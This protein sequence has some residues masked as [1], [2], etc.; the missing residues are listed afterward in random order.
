[1]GHSSHHVSIQL[2]G[3]I[4]HLLNKLKQL[5]HQ[6]SVFRYIKE[7]RYLRKILSDFLYVDGFRISTFFVVLLL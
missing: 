2:L 6:N 4:N 3:K 7:V 5:Y 1:M